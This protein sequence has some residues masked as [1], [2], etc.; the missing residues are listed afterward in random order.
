M[1]TKKFRDDRG[2]IEFLALSRI[3]VNLNHRSDYDCREVNENVL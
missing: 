2:V 1:V 3:I